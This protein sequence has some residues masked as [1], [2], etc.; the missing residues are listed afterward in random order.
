MHFLQKSP[1]IY[2][3]L[4][5]T[6][7]KTPILDSPLLWLMSRN[8]LAEPDFPL[9]PNQIQGISLEYFARRTNQVG[10]LAISLLDESNQIRRLKRYHILDFRH[11]GFQVSFYI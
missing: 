5:G 8:S 6:A 9:M 7:P 2:L 1:P 11:L 4:S 3:D 10:Y